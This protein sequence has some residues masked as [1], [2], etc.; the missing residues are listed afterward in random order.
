MGHSDPKVTL[1]I[2]TQFREEEIEAA[3]TLIRKFGERE[4]FSKK[5]PELAF[6]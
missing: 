1:G 3:G 4:N 6:F 2:Y 5:D